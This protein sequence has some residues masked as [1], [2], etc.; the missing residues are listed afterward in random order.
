MTIGD[1]IRADG[2]APRA[3]LVGIVTRAHRLGFCRWRVATA[4][5][6]S[7]RELALIEE[8][9]AAKNR[10]H[11]QPSIGGPAA[12]ELVGEG[13]QRLSRGDRPPRSS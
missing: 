10:H 13:Q 8:Q 11:H 1:D 9:I 12:E 3:E 5:E 2:A 6:A 7:Q 4:L